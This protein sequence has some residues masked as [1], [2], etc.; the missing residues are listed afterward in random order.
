LRNAATTRVFRLEKNWLN[1]YN[2]IGLLHR[3]FS[4]VIW[5]TLEISYYTPKILVS[6]FARSIEVENARVILYTN[7]IFGCG[8]LMENLAKRKLSIIDVRCPFVSLRDLDIFKQFS[9]LRALGFSLHNLTAF[10]SDWDHNI[11]SDN[12]I[13]CEFPD[14]FEKRKK[15]LLKGDTYSGITTIYLKLKCFGHDKVY[16]KSS[17]LTYFM[18][19][20]E[21]ILVLPDEDM[22][23]KFSFN[24]YYIFMEKYEAEFEYVL[25]KSNTCPQKEHTLYGVKVSMGE[26]PFSD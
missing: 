9:N 19:L 7:V 6:A 17:A 21:V 12:C 1:H 23:S 2:E 3:V 4:K 14:L 26:L 10:F 22:P 16:L 13:W 20:R 15:R 24:Q 18:D 5:S 8:A 11:T 25:K